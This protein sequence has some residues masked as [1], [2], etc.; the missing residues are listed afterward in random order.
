MRVETGTPLRSQTPG[1]ERLR[2]E[3]ALD[4]AIEH[5]FPGATRR[6]LIRIPTA[7]PRS[8]SR[9]VSEVVID[10]AESTTDH[11][12]LKKIEGL[13]HEEQH[14]YGKGELPDHDQVR[15]E[16]IKIGL[17]QCW[18]LLRQREARR[19]FGQSCSASKRLC[20]L[21][22]AR[23][24]TRPGENSS[25]RPMTLATR[26][27]RTKW[28]PEEFTEA[29]H[30][31]VVLQQVREALGRVADGTFGKCIVDGGPIEERRLE[32]VPWTPYCL[33]HEQRLEVAASSRTPTL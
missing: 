2:R 31:S 8:T 17:D 1:R 4:E 21:G 20:P 22:L 32:A 14:L 15:L 25:T 6:P 16:A 27:S 9:R 30:D 11:S 10:M 23:K 26:V 33:E 12:I 7:T 28:R 29:E 24:R 13:V 5:R 18:D 3:A 19:E